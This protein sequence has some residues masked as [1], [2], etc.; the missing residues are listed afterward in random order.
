[1]SQD[2]LPIH[3]LWVRELSIVRSEHGDRTS[4]L[5]F[6]EHLL[7]RLGL[8]EV[9][10]LEPHARVPFRVLGDEDE[11]WALIQGACTF[12]WRDER[13]GSPTSS[14]TF[15]LACDQPHLVLVP[16]GVGFGIETGSLGAILLRLASQA[17]GEG[18][19]A[20]NA[21]SARN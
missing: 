1:M 19:P 16:F 5:A 13:H 9:I 17:A 11:A 18:E 8:V 2:D 4:V 3:D 14:Q 12:T 6:E 15:E 20:S 10:R 21:S 7:G